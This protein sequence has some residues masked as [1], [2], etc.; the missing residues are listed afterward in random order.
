MTCGISRWPPTFISRSHSSSGMGLAGWIALMWMGGAVPWTVGLAVLF[1]G[2][3]IAVALWISVRHAPMPRVETRW[4]DLVL[5]AAMVA[6]LVGVVVT[7]S[8]R[9]G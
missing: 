9:I 8:F 3:V 5:R 7:L 2:M 4:Y 1:N 6:L